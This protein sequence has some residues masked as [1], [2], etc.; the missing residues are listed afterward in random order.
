MATVYHR[1]DSGAPTFAFSTSGTNIAHFAALKTIL[2]ACLVSGYGSKPAAGWILVAEGDRFLVL[3]NGTSSGFVCFTWVA[4]TSYFNIHLAATFTG[5]SGDVMTGAGL[6]SG[7]EAAGSAN[8]HRMWNSV[9]AHSSS[10]STWYLIA[11]EKTFYFQGSGGFSLF[12]YASSDFGAMNPLY[13]GEDSAGNFLAMGGQNT[14]STQPR[15]YF[16][17]EGVTVLRNPATGLLVDTG[18]IVV[19]APGLRLTANANIGVATLGAA[20]IVP[21]LEAPLCPVRWGASVLAGRL[22]GQALCPLVSMYYPSP[23]AQSLGHVGPLN[24]RNLNTPLP[25]G[26][27]YTYFMGVAFDGSPTRIVTNNPEFW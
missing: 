9:L 26:G 16:G 2:K 6:K 7:T 25:L 11:D 13:V 10:N 1:D 14:N 4:A 17:P 24:S 27:A 18:S 12:E 8:Q 20:H 3:R 15:A 5:M 19:V 23:A 21:L 22:R